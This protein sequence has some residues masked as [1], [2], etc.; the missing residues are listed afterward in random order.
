MKQLTLIQY[1]RLATSDN[2]IERD[3]FQMIWWHPYPAGTYERGAPTNEMKHT[4]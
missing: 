3:V 4:Q 1:H 2:E